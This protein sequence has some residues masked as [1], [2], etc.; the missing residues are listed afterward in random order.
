MNSIIAFLIDDGFSCEEAFFIFKKVTE[1]LLPTN[2][3][4]SMDT[5]MVY[6]RIFYEMLN[7]THPKCYNRMKEISKELDNSFVAMVSFVLQ[8]F[9]CLF[10]NDNIHI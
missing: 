8:W 5:I 9:V 6:M 1:G 3:Y 10:C 7:F 4:N 2:Y